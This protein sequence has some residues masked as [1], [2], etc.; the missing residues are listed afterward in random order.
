MSQIIGHFVV[1]KA[2]TLDSLNE[3]IENFEHSHTA[4]TNTPQPSKVTSLLSFKIKQIAC[5]MWNL[6]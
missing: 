1:H 6:I 5:E 3:K 2:F 4:K